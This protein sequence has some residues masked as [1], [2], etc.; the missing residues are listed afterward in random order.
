MRE[1]AAAA[2]AAARAAG[3]AQA[4][5]AIETTRLGF[6]RFAGSRFTQ[7]GEVVTPRV[8]I[9]AYVGGARGAVET[10]TLTR[11]A[12][13][14]A[15]VQAV[16]V[17][18]A[19]PPP[20]RP[21]P[22]PA[23]PS[24]RPVAA[25]RLPAATLAADAEARAAIAGAIFAALAPHGLAAAGCVKTWR[26]QRTVVTSAGADVSAEDVRAQVEL[27]ATGDRDASGYASFAGADLAALDPRALAEEAAACALRNR[28]A[29][30]LAAGR[31]DVVL[32]PTAMA[33][34]IDWL[35]MT[36]F[37]AR[38][39]LDGASLLC[40]H[41]PGASICDPRVDLREEPFTTEPALAISPY[42]SEGT[43][44]RA[45]RLIADGTAG[46]AVSDRATASETGDADDSSGHAQALGADLV[47]APEA[48]HLIM[49]AGDASVDEL[50][51]RCERGLYVTR[52]HYVNGFLDPRRAL[53]TGLTRDGTFRIERGTLGA[54]VAN[55]RWTDSLLGGLAPARLLG[56]GRQRALNLA[57]WSNGQSLL[58]HVAI[59]G[60][61][62]D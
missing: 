8:R 3:A 7:S 23:A 18:R 59:R 11:D 16:A 34:V 19:L 57:G 44:R 51:G 14:S 60:W 53:M 40:A 52:F 61:T 49:A 46:G 32:S 58:P 30:P 39:V 54:P 10:G 13:A 28:G 47:D 56:V 21:V 37:S 31:Y 43:P 5:V 27:I 62:F 9:R 24:A 38:A 1:L 48:A 36:S 50:L 45:V 29:K 42:D 20:A 4:E 12:L 55:A 22:P 35:V 33:E 17:A 41:P 6:A 2:L 15:A 26:R 25:Q